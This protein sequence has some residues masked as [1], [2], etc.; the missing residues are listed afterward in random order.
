LGG[1]TSH[2]WTGGARV[3]IIDR[4]AIRRGVFPSVADLIAKIRTFIT[5]WNQRKH[6]HLDQ[7]ARRHPEQHQP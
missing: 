3:G 5:G 7:D 4:Q 2:G 1:I 6:P